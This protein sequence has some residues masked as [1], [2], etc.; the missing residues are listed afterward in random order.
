MAESSKSVAD[1][2]YDAQISFAKAEDR[3]NDLLDNAV[4]TDNW[5]SWTADYYDRSIEIYGIPKGLDTAKLCNALHAEGFHLLWVHDH[6]ETQEAPRFC[7]CKAHYLI[8]G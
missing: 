8:G 3:V 4:G 2:F 7:A 1:E 6:P 5:E